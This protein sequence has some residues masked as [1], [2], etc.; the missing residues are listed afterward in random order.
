MKNYTLIAVFLL[1]LS[2]AGCG[3][4]A[5]G[6]VSDIVLAGR[7]RQVQIG[8]GSTTA[9]CPA[10]LSGQECGASDTVDFLA[11][12]FT[13]TTGAGKTT[14]VYSTSGNSV[15]LSIP[16]VPKASV[17]GSLVGGKLVMRYR[18]DGK[19]FSDTYER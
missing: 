14:G 18:A 2:L 16:G 1:S 5:G 13:L 19:D 6:S 10:T 12:A 17:S 4:S 11:G 7:W 9:A 8:D 15:T 3:G